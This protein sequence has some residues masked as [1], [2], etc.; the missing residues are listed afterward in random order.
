M[1]KNCFEQNIIIIYHINVHLKLQWTIKTF[2]FKDTQTNNCY[3]G[4]SQYVHCADCRAIHNK[5]KTLMIKCNL[6]QENTYLNTCICV[7]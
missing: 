6:I 4:L 3:W 5:M 1:E 7:L 2:Y